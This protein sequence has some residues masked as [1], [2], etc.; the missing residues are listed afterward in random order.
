MRVQ[1]GSE[2]LSSFVEIRT[3]TQVEGKSKSPGGA[4]E[5]QVM[6]AKLITLETWAATTYGESSPHINTMR[7]GARDAHIYPKPVKHGR[8]YFVAP[9]A[10]YVDFSA[11]PSGK[12][13]A[14]NSR[15]VAKL[16]HGQA[17]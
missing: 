8:T 14:S 10:R 13:A 1:L 16:S 5:D 17:A 12:A 11:M 6:A 15:L 3:G 4:A 7:R 9:D 2:S